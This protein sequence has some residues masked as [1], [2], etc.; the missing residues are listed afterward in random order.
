MVL[1]GELRS[2]LLWPGYDLRLDTIV[3]DMLHGDLDTLMQVLGMP[4]SFTSSTVAGAER[5]SAVQVAFAYPDAIVRASGSSLVPGPYGVRG[6]YRA[7][8]TGG[9]LEHSFVADFTGQ[10][11]QPVVDEYTDKGHRQL[12]AD[13]PDAYT[14]MI[15]HVLACLHGQAVN[16]LAPA[17]V[18]D[19]LRLTLDVHQAVNR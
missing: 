14:A 7:S 6:G 2:A 17:S 3:L 19:S 11:P 9:V 5:G 1:R 4:E 18:L 12:P 10:A 8:I 15:D 13:G 16:Q